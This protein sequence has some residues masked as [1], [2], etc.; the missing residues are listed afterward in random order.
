M[1]PEEKKSSGSNRSFNNTEH[2]EPLPEKQDYHSENEENENE[3][4]HSDSF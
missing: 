4:N 3:E 1:K 2:N